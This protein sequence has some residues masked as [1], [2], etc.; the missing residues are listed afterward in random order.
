MTQA[1][2]DSK[3][4]PLARQGPVCVRVQTCRADWHAAAARKIQ[5]SKAANLS[6][7]TNRAYTTL[8]V[9]ALSLEAMGFSQ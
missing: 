5:L 2:S 6:A 7:V 3:K 9:S 1:T 8:E 4:V